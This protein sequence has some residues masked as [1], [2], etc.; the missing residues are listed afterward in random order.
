MLNFKFWK[1][2]NGRQF[3]L[4]QIQQISQIQKNVNL[5]RKCIKERVKK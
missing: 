1:S 4:K 3:F 2:K 5:K